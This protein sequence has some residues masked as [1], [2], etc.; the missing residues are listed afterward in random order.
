MAK[1]PKKALTKS[2]FLAELAEKT[3]L[4]KKQVDAVLAGIVEMVQRELSGKGVG[5]LV[6]PGLARMSVTKV[7]AVKGGVEKK[8]PLNGQMYV[9][10]DKPAYNKVRVSPIKALKESLK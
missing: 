8:N 7:K 2:A 9:T 6:I 10:K 4:T 1:A 3:E 5:K